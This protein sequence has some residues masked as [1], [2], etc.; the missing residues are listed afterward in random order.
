MP[1]VIVDDLPG[2]TKR[3]HNPGAEGLGADQ[4]HAHTFTTLDSSTVSL[5]DRE[6]AALIFDGDDLHR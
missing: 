2:E 5:D 4:D 6:V 1:I 3:N